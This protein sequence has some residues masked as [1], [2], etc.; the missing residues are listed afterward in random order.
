[1]DRIT[2]FEIY[3]SQGIPY[4]LITDP[5]AEMIEIYFLQEG[6]YELQVLDNQNTFSFLLGDDCKADVN[7]AGVFK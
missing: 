1:R 6:K 5:D 4:Y 3:Q 2:K 7:F